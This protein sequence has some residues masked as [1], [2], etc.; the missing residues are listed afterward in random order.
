[1]TP[2]LHLLAALVLVAGCASTQTVEAATES[3]EAATSSVPAVADDDVDE[4]AS[5]DDVLE[6]YP[7]DIPDETIA[8]PPTDFILEPANAQLTDLDGWVAVDE[9]Y[10]EPIGFAPSSCDVF[11]DVLLLE[12]WGIVTGFWLKDGTELFH[13]TASLNTADNVAAYVESFMS[14]AAACPEIMM[15]DAVLS[16]SL[17]EAAGFEGFTMSVDG[18]ANATWLFELGSETSA[19]IMERNNVVSIVQIGPSEAKGFDMAEF[20]EL[21]QRAAARLTGVRPEEPASLED[22]SG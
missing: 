19:V 7:E 2:R 18:P 12:E 10:W 15:G 20:D 17:F 8:P 21:V 16:L 4:E 3:T 1:M 11:N 6:D 9:W 14:V 13:F 22:E 5:D